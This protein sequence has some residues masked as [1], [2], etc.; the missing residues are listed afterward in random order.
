MLS[1]ASQLVV[2][3]AERYAYDEEILRKAEELGKPGAVEIKQLQDVFIFRVESTGVL[4]AEAIV[5]QSVAL[6][7]EKMA[8][9]KD[10]ILQ[11]AAGLE[12]P[13]QDMELGA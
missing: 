4:S 7:L 12:N 9:V 10:L 11:E 5:M 8:T 3:D 6:L 2:E 1:S 13:A